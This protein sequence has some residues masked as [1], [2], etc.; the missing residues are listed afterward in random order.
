M[1]DDENA[2]E[3][4]NDQVMDDADK[5]DFKK[6]E[7]EKH[8]DQQART[9]QTAKDD[10]AR[11]YI[12]ETQKEK[13]KVPP[14]SSSISL[15]S[16]YAPL[17]DVFVSVIPP[18]TSTT[19]IP[20]PLPTPLII[21][22][23][24][25]IT[26]TV[27]D[28]LPAVIQ[29]LLDL[30]KKFELW[31]KVDHFEAIEASLQ[32]NLIN[33]VKNQL[34][35]LL[36]KEISNLVNLRIERLVH[37]VKILF[38]K[39]DKSRSYMS[40]DKHQELYDALLNSIMLDEAIANQGKKKRR[41]EKD[42]GPPKD[43]QAGSSKKDKST[44][45]KQPRRPPTP[46]HEWNK[47]KS[48]KDGSEQNWLNDMANAENPLLSFDD[49]MSTP[50]DFTAFV[51][52]RL[53]LTKLTKAD[54]FGYGYLKEIVVR[55]ADQKLYKFMKGDFLNLHLNDIKDMLHLNVQHKLFN[56]EG[57]I[58]IDLVAALRMY[59][60]RI[61]I[62]K[63]VE[64]VQL[65]VESF[66]N[67]LNITKTQTHYANISFKEPYTAQSKLQGVIYKDQQKQKR[68]MCTDEL[69]KFSDI[70]LKYVCNTLHQRLLNFRLG[71]NK[72]M[73][74]RKWTE[75]GSEAVTQYDVKD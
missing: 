33:E 55:R 14:T 49:L 30:E 71:Y 1:K 45:F 19:P 3:V 65:G 7:E 13:P 24:P 22:E 46:D 34:P 21:S 27:H 44:W 74:M 66:Q 9:D 12:S 67:K 50:I 16:N 15:S 39:M 23:A 43:D 47:G 36:L 26:I 29:R 28:P 41:K 64:Y 56:L 17:L 51:M 52:N 6:M 58:I 69:Y 2:D 63:R 59:T 60:Q 35:T 32:A 54:L 68:L 10:Q 61:V 70:T 75:K 4:K 25:T 8:D 5:E 48:V 38:D 62:Q 42:S 18:Q 11:A 72:D 20:T 37:V 73:E 53:K 57:D 31:T 40:Y